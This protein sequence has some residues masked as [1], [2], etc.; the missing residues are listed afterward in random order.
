MR[1]QGGKARQAKAIAK[2]LTAQ[3]RPMLI[4]PFVGSAWVTARVAAMFEKVVASDLHEDIILLHQAIQEGWRPPVAISED[5]YAAI[6]Q[7]PPSALR[8]FAGHG[9]SFGGRW[10]E[11]YA[12]SARPEDYVGESG[13]SLV[14]RHGSLGAVRFEHCDYGDHVPGTDSVVYCD[15]PYVGLK[16]LGQTPP[17]DHSRFWSTMDDWSDRGALVFVSEVTAPDTWA[18]VLALDVTRGLGLG[19]EKT[20]RVDCL[21]KRRD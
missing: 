21:W 2:V 6:R 13:R 5:E 4:E 15:P 8:G 3:G 11:G 1:Y 19:N 18:P 17:F 9:A 20:Q 12:R 16:P 10:F 14:R 7:G